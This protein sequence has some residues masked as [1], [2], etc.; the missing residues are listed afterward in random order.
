MKNKIVVCIIILLAVI[1]IV[2]LVNIM[3]TKDNDSSPD[4]QVELVER[5]DAVDTVEEVNKPEYCLLIEEDFLVV[6]LSSTGEMYFNTG[7]N[8]DELSP[9]ILD[10]IG[11][12]LGFETEEELFDFLENYSS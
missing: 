1:G 7:I 6:Y 2:W 12:G 11:Q 4:T 5:E 3:L 10:R 9:D 8:A